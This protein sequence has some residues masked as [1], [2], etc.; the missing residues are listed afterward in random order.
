MSDDNKEL[1]SA[2][3]NIEDGQEIMSNDEHSKVPETSVSDSKPI[4]ITVSRVWAKVAAFMLAGFL[5]FIAGAFVTHHGLDDGPRR[6]DHRGGPGGNSRMHQDDDQFGPGHMMPGNGQ[7]MPG[8]G[9]DLPDC[10]NDMPVTP[11][12]RN[13]NDSPVNPEDST[14]SPTQTN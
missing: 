11:S 3:Q 13:Q 4:T 7:M 5:G 2:T 8:H 6:G 1:D 12:C 9:M 10:P 14:D